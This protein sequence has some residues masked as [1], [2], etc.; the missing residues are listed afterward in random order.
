MLRWVVESNTEDLK[1]LLGWLISA[2]HLSN[3]SKRRRKVMKKRKY[4]KRAKNEI[5]TQSFSALAISPWNIFPFSSLTPGMAWSGGTDPPSEKHLIRTEPKIFH[6]PLLTTTRLIN[7]PLHPLLPRHK[8]SQLEYFGRSWKF[9]A[10]RLTSKKGGGGGG[11]ITFNGCPRS[12]SLTCCP[13]ILM[14]RRPR[15]R[16][17]NRPPEEHSLMGDRNSSSSSETEGE[18]KMIVF[19]L[20]KS[21]SLD[22]IAWRRRQKLKRALK[23]PLFFTKKKV[24]F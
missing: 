1:I 12:R 15:A 2:E 18:I 24:F 7:N 10:A 4:S 21:C 3:P 5:Q 14:G 13:P 11:C 23:S 8:E 17:Q 20:R 19:Y 9:F 22:D 16:T 6:P